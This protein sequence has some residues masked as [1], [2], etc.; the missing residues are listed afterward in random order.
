[1]ISKDSLKSVYCRREI[2]Y[3]VQNGKRL[4]PVLR[5][6]DF[7]EA[8]K[9][10]QLSQHQWVTFQEQ[11]D[12][13]TCFANLVKAINTD[14][15]YKQTHTRL[16]LRA[17]EWKQAKQNPSLL[18][19]GSTLNDAE[20]WLLQAAA[21]KD[22]RP[23]ELQGEFI[24]TSRQS[25]TQEQSQANR[26]QR[27]TIAALSGLLL[28]A[29]GAGGVAWGQRQ[30]A[31]KREVNTRLRTL[32]AMR[33]V[34]Y[35]AKERE[36]LIG[37]SAAV[38]AVAYSPDGETIATGS[39]DATV[40]LWNF[41]LEDLIA[42]GCDW[43]GT[44]FVK[45]SPELLME[46]EV[47]QDHNPDWLITAVPTLVGQGNSLAEAEQSEQRQEKLQMAKAFVARWTTYE[48]GKAYKPQSQDWIDALE[49]GENPFTPKL[50][51]ELRNQIAP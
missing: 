48:E 49:Q 15:E 17:I 25:T 6:K 31:I 8:D 51:E 9:H 29:I 4:I 2:D 27:M 18:L 22:P 5:R 38:R 45:Q 16:Q 24:A 33:E 1:V 41:Q 20:Q 30:R 11:D 3:A 46:L 37:H 26:R 50:L 19:R 34:V 12:F 40:K 42:R 43:L 44:Y 14:L 13:E 47:C 35:E 7:V 28:V 10:P 36:R 39:L 23:T 32:A 21:G